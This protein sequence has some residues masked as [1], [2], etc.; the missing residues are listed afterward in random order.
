MLSNDRELRGKLKPPIPDVET[1]SY[2]AVQILEKHGEL[3]FESL[4]HMAEQMEGTATLT[5]VTATANGAVALLA[6]NGGH[7]TVKSGTYKGSGNNIVQM[8]GSAASSI[9]VEGLQRTMVVLPSA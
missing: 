8:S 7:I 1:D 3:G 5:N 2:V 4:Y 6:Q 9:I